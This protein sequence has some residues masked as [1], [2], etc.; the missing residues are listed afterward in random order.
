MSTSAFSPVYVLHSEVLTVLGSKDSFWQDLC[1]GK[2]GLRPL[3]ETYPDWFPKD[4]RHVG[5]LAM[6]EGG[7]RLEVILE[8]LL[9]LFDDRL[10]ESIDSVYAATSLGDLIGSYAGAPQKIIRNACKKPVHT[11]SSAC[12]SGSDALSLGTLAIRAG[13]ADILLILAIDSLCPAKLS[14]HIALGTQSPAKARPF[15]LHRDG[16]SFGEGGAFLILASEKGLDR[17][18]LKPEAKI[19]KV[20]YCLASEWPMEPFPF[21]CK[22]VSNVDNCSVVLISIQLLFKFG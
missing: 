20:G 7:S 11:V 3:C 17:L 6:E 18:Q 13:K 8:R 9:S 5:A 2:S 16:T 1:A 12:S 19:L 22:M 15:D 21:F 14:H 10:W 4:E